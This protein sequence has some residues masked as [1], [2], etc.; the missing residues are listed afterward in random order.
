MN[1]CII[2]VD[3][4]PKFIGGIKR[5]STILATEWTSKGHSVFFLTVTNSDFREDTINGIPQFYLP[6]YKIRNSSINI[7]YFQN[8][9]KNKKIEKKC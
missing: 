3:N 2:N 6:D 5:V 9:I 4:Q 1:I 8:L 7:Q